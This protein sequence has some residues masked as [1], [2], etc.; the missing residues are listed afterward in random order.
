[1][2]QAV[3]RDCSEQGRAGVLDGAVACL[4]RRA[5]RGSAGRRC[6]TQGRFPR[7]D[8]FSGVLEL[9]TSGAGSAA[10]SE[11]SRRRCGRYGRGIAQG[12]LGGRGSL[13][14][15]VVS[16]CNLRDYLYISLASDNEEGAGG[17]GALQMI[18]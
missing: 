7:R 15:C 16:S 12:H 1:M 3:M 17:A 14:G 5:R 8:S 2:L 4:V 6:W 10:G 18:S 9:C 13:D 11:C